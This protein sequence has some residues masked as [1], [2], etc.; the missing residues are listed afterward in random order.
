MVPMHGP[1]RKE[2]FRGLDDWGINELGYGARFF[3]AVGV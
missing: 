1:E 3:A 2:A